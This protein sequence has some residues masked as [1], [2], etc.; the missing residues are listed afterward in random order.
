MCFLVM[1]P[2]SYD[3]LKITVHTYVQYTSTTCGFS[4]V[5]H[6][7]LFMMSLHNYVY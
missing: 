3:F 7:Y 5:E 6:Q 2:F 4:M 1:S